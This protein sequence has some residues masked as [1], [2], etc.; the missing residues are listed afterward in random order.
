MQE[1]EIQTEIIV[2]RKIY[3]IINPLTWTKVKAAIEKFKFT[4]LE[5]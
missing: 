1:N 4:E 5:H 3:A 2:K